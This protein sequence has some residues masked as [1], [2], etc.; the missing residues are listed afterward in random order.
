MTRR[1]PLEEPLVPANR[2]ETPAT[3]NRHGIGGGPFTSW[4]RSLRL[5]FVSRGNLCGPPE[6]R[7]RGA[8][9]DPA[10]SGE[11]CFCAH[12]AACV[13]SVTPI[14]SKIRVTWFLTVFS[15]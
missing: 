14:V 15:A 4:P 5:T 7:K 11:K 13:R 10:S 6:P 1:K 8:Q 3:A 12:N 2:L 9:D